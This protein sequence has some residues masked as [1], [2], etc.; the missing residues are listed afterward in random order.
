MKLS[1]WQQFSSNHSAAFSIVA[2][3]ESAE[4]AQAVAAQVTEM[5]L[6]T[7]RWKEYGFGE[8]GDFFSPI[9]IRQQFEYHVAFGM[10]WMLSEEHMR[11]ALQVNGKEIYV[12]DAPG[13]SNFDGSDMAFIT[14]FEKFGAELIAVREEAGGSVFLS[15]SAEAVDEKVAQSVI[16]Q[17]VERH[18][19]TGSK[20]KIHHNIETEVGYHPGAEAVRRE[21][22]RLFFESV[23]L[24]PHLKGLSYWYQFIKAFA[25]EKLVLT[26]RN[27]SSQKSLELELDD[28]KFKKLM[29]HSNNW[30]KTVEQTELV[31][32]EFENET[33]AKT[34]SVKICEILLSVQ[35]WS[36]A[37]PVESLHI[38]E[39]FWERLSPLEAALKLQY[40]IEWPMSV[41]EWI[42]HCKQ[43]ADF[44]V[45]QIDKRVFLANKNNSWIGVS[46]FDQLLEKSGANPLKR[47]TNYGSRLL[48]DFEII[49]PNALETETLRRIIE[50]SRAEAKYPW[51]PLYRNYD[52]SRNW[53]ADLAKLHQQDT[54]AKEYGESFRGLVNDDGELR[55][56]S[57]LT[58]FL[59]KLYTIPDLFDEYTLHLKAIV[60]D[61]D[62]SFNKIYTQENRLFIEGGQFQEAASFLGLEA[63]VAWLRSKHCEVHLSIPKPE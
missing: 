19:S 38:W 50:D 20:D 14:L 55:H 33:V 8:R 61:C 37:Y 23:Y 36:K 6:E 60:R 35:E 43:A 51:L 45:V 22:Q 54:E 30:T 53:Q 27:E 25:L 26:F 63:F 2:K 28:I 5:L 32:G 10:T 11:R 58:E 13:Y 16:E 31:I 47:F 46:P 40:G 34:V 17:L 62:F 44:M 4:K 1:I 41:I 12:S 48:L 52:K 57:N 15:L 24:D 42:H 7:Y 9:Q 18:R 59:Q 21:G 49:V 3:F 39:A 29:W 56:H